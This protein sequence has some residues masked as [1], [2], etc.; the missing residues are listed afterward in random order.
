MTDD[1]VLFNGT[2]VTPEKTIPDAVVAVSGG[3]IT[4]LGQSMAEAKQQ[5]SSARY[6]DLNGFYL[7]PGFIDLHV[8]GGNGAD[9]YD[10][11]EKGFSTITEFYAQS[12][13]TA[14]LAT[15]TTGSLERMALAIERV[16]TFI[17]SG[18]SPLGA[19]VAGIYLEGPFCN[20][21]RKGTFKPEYLLLP[22]WKIIEPWIKNYGRW[23]TFLGLAPELPGANLVIDNLRHFGVRPCVAHSDASFTEMEDAINRGVCHATHLFNGMRVFHH[24][25]PGLATAILLNDEVT[26]ELICDF[27][28]VHE[29]AIRLLLK[30]KKPKNVCLITDGMRAE[31]LPD[32]NYLISEQMAVLKNGRVMIGNDTL[33]GSALTMEQAVKNMV[34]LGFGMSEVIQMATATP[35]RVAGISQERGSIEKGKIADLVILDQELSVL[36]TLL[37]GTNWVFKPGKEGIL[38]EKNVFIRDRK[39]H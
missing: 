29:A 21:K 26:A 15:V 32:G 34:K 27:H 8:H 17:Q 23:I 13:T 10:A 31:G 33:A 28:H 30:C 35:A 4:Y 14:L 25:E 20:V 38:H 22:D 2:A 18:G 7:A 39:T 1:L 5:Y 37:R 24:R 11:E 36:A 9:F 12:G 6:L 3:R 19:H 16:A